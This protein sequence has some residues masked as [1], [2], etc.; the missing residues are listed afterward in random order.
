MA[1]PGMTRAWR[2]SPRGC[3]RTLTFGKLFSLAEQTPPRTLFL[4]RHHGQ[5]ASA[6]SCSS[7]YSS[8]SVEVGDI[9]SVW[10]DISDLLAKIISNGLNPE[11][12]EPLMFLFRIVRNT[13][14]N[15][16]VNQDRAR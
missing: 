7:S 12:I 14:A 8:T 10:T 9:Q 2:L 4:S 16:P 11:Q 15:V 3:K 6:Y 13:A 1:A 5:D